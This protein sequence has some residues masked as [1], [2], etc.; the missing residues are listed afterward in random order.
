MERLKQYLFDRRLEALT[1]DP[2]ATGHAY[3]IQ[4]HLNVVN[5]VDALIEKGASM[6]D[7]GKYI[8][9]ECI[10]SEK[11]IKEIKEK[12]AS[13][14]KIE[15]AFFE[16]PNDYHIADGRICQCVELNSFI[17]EQK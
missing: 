12:H 17:K 16:F 15:K 1:E 6:Y 5:E 9:D 10:K 14:D 2:I 13:L 11:Y 8:Q 4:G 3:H 7:V